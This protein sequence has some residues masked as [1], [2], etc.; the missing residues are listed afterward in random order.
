MRKFKHLL[1]FFITGITILNAQNYEIKSLPIHNNGGSNTAINIISFDKDDVLWYNTHNGMIK[2]FESSQIFY[3]F[4]DGKKIVQVTKV[5]SILLDSKGRF[6]I[7]TTEGVFRSETSKENFQRLHWP[8]LD[9]IKSS[10][11]SYTAEDCS[12]NIWV[13]I[14]KTQILKITSDTEFKLFNTAKVDSKDEH[15]DLSLRNASNCDH[16]LMQKGPNYFVINEETSQLSGIP[17]Q[18]K[19]EDYDY[20]YYAKNK[21]YNIFKNGEVFPKDF[22][23]VYNYNGKKLEV[24]FLKASNLQLIEVPY[25]L[26]AI[27]GAKYPILK[28]NMDFIFSS[29]AHARKFGVLKL[30]KENDEYYL[31]EIEEIHFDYLIEYLK[32]ANNGIIYVSVFDKIHKIK[33]K[34]KGFKKSLYNQKNQGE[35]INISTRDFLEISE[36]EFLVASYGG[37]F[38]LSVSSSNNVIDELNVFPTLNYCRAHAKVNDSIALSL[39]ETSLVSINYKKKEVIEIKNFSKDYEDIIFF[40]I[41]KHTDSTYLLASNYG[42]G[43]YNFKNEKLKPYKLFPLASDT[44]KFVR[45]INYRNNTLYFSTQTDGLFIQNTLT[46]KVFNIAYNENQE[47]LPSNYVYTSFIDSN[48]NLWIGTNKGIACYNKEQEK[49]FSLDRQNGLLDENIV[50]IQEDKLRNIWFSTYKGLYKYN[51]RLKTVLSYFEGD[52]LPDNEFNQN[53]YYTATD[54]TLFFGGVNG[55]VTF[56][57]IE[58]IVTEVKIL[59][60]KIEYFDSKKNRDTI[61]TN[62]VNADNYIRLDTKNSS[63]SVTFSINDF[64]NIENNRYLYKVDGLSDKWINLGN[65]NTLKLFSIPPGNY[66]LKI[67]GLNSKGIQSFNE[68]SY[69]IYVPQM[70]YKRTWFLLVNIILFIAIFIVIVINYT[71]KQKKK[72]KMNLMLIEL[73]QKALRAQMNPHFIFNTLNGMRKKV[74]KGASDEVENYIISFSEF[75]RHTLDVGRRENIF[76]SKEIQYITSYIDL[77]S[78]RNDR[79]ISL[80]VYCDSSINQNTTAI[81]SMILQPLVE[82]AVI[83]SFPKNQNNNLI[84]LIIKK[85]SLKNQIEVILEDNGIGINVSKSNENISTSSHLSHATQIVNERFELMNKTKR[86]K[87]ALYKMYVEDISEESKTGTRVTINIPFNN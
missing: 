14:S 10:H 76:L 23:G 86:N 29:N 58:N 18:Y 81:P 38:K 25:G 77:I 12:G 70:L 55:I 26:I 22:E 54:G 46:D 48:D 1:M 43:V 74:I 36:N 68:L 79:N 9:S 40:D 63:V 7:N 41:Q 39:G 87:I 42:I 19:L 5:N 15:F 20:D 3:P 73:E 53:S 33:V 52:G 83:H 57:T 34:N 49:L 16:I 61:I 59:P 2:E 64:F 65:Q 13:G 44:S 85:N 27:S 8:I 51:P 47:E 69:S 72:Y 45:D 37:T 11:L 4:M 31:K 82:N 24:T 30:V 71:A 32:I 28:E 50:G 56:D 67:K 60:T 80:D 75:L 62:A 35:K 84:H 6:W 17:I 66:T 21:N 78:Y